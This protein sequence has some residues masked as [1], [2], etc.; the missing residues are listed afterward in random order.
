MQELTR[1]SLLVGAGAVALAA[2]GS[3]SKTKGTSATQAAGTPSPVTAASGPMTLVARFPNDALLVPGTPRVAVS[4]AVGGTI[5]A[6][7]PATMQGRILD[8]SGAKLADVNAKLRNTGTTT[9][10]WAFRP[11]LDTPGFY[12]LRVDG[13][14][15]SGQAFQ[16]ADPATVTMPH[17][18][19]VLPPFDT[20]TVADHR[21]V[22]PYCSLTPQPCPLHDITL[23][24]ALKRGKPVVYMVGTPAHCQ[25]GACA[26][27][28]E[29][30]VGAHQRLGDKVA[31]VHADVYA[32]NA[33]TKLAPAVDALGLSYEPV[34]YL[35][36]PDGTIVDHLD[37]VWDATELDESLAALTT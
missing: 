15:G 2:C 20:P 34:V 32:D 26:P 5:Q 30:L 11:Q 16:I 29:L 1:R 6:G 17:T 35:C 37:G 18:G 28:L 3:S 31:M 21:G 10:Y 7:G 4:I 9:A 13:D 36:K 19:G 23:T 22:E 27:A 8:Q 25:T 33:G 14:D 24:D 12:T